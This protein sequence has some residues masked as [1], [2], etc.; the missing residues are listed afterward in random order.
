[1]GHA[2]LVRSQVQ[3]PSHVPVLVQLDIIMVVV[4]LALHALQVGSV[5][6][7]D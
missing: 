4:L 2:Q 6:Q 7:V 1:V 5:I 3:E